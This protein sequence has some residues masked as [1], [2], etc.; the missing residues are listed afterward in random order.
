MAV[1]SRISAIS[2]KS[3][4][5][6][7]RWLSEQTFVD[8]VALCQF[9]PGPASSQTGFAIGLIR[10][11]YAG[12]LAAWAGFTLPSAILLV[13]FAYGAGALSGTIGI[14]LLHGLKL[15]A[16][17]IV[18]QAV[19][20]MARSLTPDRERASIAT[21][22]ALIIL[23]STSSVAQ[24]GAI[25]LGGLLGLWL[26]REAPPMMEGHIAIPVTRRV[27]F[28]ALAAFSILLV[29]LP[30]AQ[31]LS[32]SSAIARSR[33]HSV[34]PRDVCR[35]SMVGWSTG[36]RMVAVDVAIAHR[37]P[38]DV[39]GWSIVGVEGRGGVGARTHVNRRRPMSAC[40]RRRL[41]GYVA[42]HLGHRCTSHKAPWRHRRNNACG[43]SLV[44]IATPGPTGS[45]RDHG[46]GSRWSKG[47]QGGRGW[48]LR[49]VRCRFVVEIG[50]PERQAVS[51]RAEDQTAARLVSE[52][53]CGYGSE[54]SENSFNFKQ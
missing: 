48:G 35:W 1:R 34:G 49:R 24:V 5:F 38:R 29:G 44:A 46:T 12:A 18:A 3:S 32:G 47:S 39:A 10:A 37:G 7:R 15:V 20:G 52:D 42:S 21:L 31:K 13:L 9:L 50:P 40:A 2:A 28:S 43:R 45:R 36:T 4:P 33:F 8:L 53:A 22:S 19:W 17:A 23:F 11:G 54:N 41:A 16:V 26:C 27:G 51:E 30:I 25:V 14:R 6:R